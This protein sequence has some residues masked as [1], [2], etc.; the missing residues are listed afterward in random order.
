MFERGLAPCFV[1]DPPVPIT[2]AATADGW[3][4]QIG[5]VSCNRYVVKLASAL[6]KQLLRTPSSTKE[7]YNLAWIVKQDI[8][9]AIE[10]IIRDE[11][12]ELFHRMSKPLDTIEL[13]LWD[14]HAL[15][16]SATVWRK[17][18]GNWKNILRHQSRGLAESSS[19]LEERG[20]VPETAK[21][22]LERSKLT[23]TLRGLADDTDR[24]ACRIE[25]TL[26]ALL[27]S[28]VTVDSTQDE[29]GEEDGGAEGGGAE[30]GG[31]EG[32]GGEGGGEEH[33]R[34][35]DVGDEDGGE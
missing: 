9:R 8:R 16:K 31:E 15:M 13:G 4:G 28:S 20:L 10:G 12:N 22:G 23:A 26:Q 1:L 30:G 24:M 19:K 35:E 29:D 25:A 27:L 32:G 6:Q 21:T 2:T 11:V 7:K 18:L 3:M 34:E 17:Q 14:E 5:L 33:G